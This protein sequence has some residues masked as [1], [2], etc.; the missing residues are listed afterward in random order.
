MR[1]TSADI[2]DRSRS[3]GKP[4]ACMSVGIDQGFSLIHYL[5]ACFCCTYTS[6]LM[7]SKTSHHWSKEDCTEGPDISTVHTSCH[8]SQKTHLCNGP[9][10]IPRPPCPHSMPIDCYLAKSLRGLFHFLWLA[11]QV[12]CVICIPVQQ[13]LKSNRPLQLWT[14][15]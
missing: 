13:N 15:P 4:S 11:V 3:P 7:W 1:M 6:A 10:S 14:D 9:L 8:R 12:A 5:Q 2:A